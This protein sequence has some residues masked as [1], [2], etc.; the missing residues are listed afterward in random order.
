MRSFDDLGKKGLLE[1]LL[2]GIDKQFDLGGEEMRVIPIWQGQT[3]EEVVT[4]WEKKHGVF[5][6]DGLTI[7]IKKFGPKR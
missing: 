1:R 5:A 3:E 4:D 7:F 6:E 2:S